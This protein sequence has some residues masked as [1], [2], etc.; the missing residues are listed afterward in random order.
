MSQLSQFNACVVRLCQAA[1]TLRDLE[2][3]I[4]RESDMQTVAELMGDATSELSTIHRHTERSL[5][6]ATDM[7]AAIRVSDV[8]VCHQRPV[9][10]EAT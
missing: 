5:Q 6:L 2:R 9:L 3:R 4:A 10:K 7:H 1:D 8:T